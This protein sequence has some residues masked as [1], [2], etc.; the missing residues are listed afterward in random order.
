MPDDKPTDK[1]VADIQALVANAQIQQDPNVSQDVKDLANNLMPS[2]D[3][4]KK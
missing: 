3:Q 2:S 4:F 1:D